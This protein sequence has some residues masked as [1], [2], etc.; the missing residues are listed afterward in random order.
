MN[1]VHVYE[2]DV[3]WKR[4]LNQLLAIPDTSDVVLLESENGLAN[5]TDHTSEPLARRSFRA[6]NPVSRYSW[7][8]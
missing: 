4:H 5:Q 3:I 1:S 6:R 7:E 2:S 8:N